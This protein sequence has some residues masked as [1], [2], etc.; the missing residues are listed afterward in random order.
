AE[1][2]RRQADDSC[3]A[4][5]M[6]RYG[7]ADIPHTAATDHRV[8]RRAGRPA[9][10]EAEARPGEVPLVSF[11]RG[12]EGVDDAEDDRSRAVALERLAG[13]GDGASIGALGRVLPAREAACRRDPDDPAAAEARG[14]ALALQE[15]PAEALA[16][17][18]AVL[19][20][21]PERELALVG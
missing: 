6:P 17:F 10:A 14:Y 1:R 16:A 19:A 21:A 7:A 4:C 2:R 12:R 15:R 5:H 11:F 20:R 13:G 3:V 9:A 18:E 8:P